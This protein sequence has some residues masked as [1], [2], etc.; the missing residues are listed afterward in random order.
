MS[1]SSAPRPSIKAV[2][3]DLD[4]TLLDTEQ[5]SDKA[6]LM[7]F[8]RDVLPTNV[9][10]ECEANNFLLPWELKKQL[11][12]LRGSE[13]APK[14]IA[15]AHQHWGVP[16]DGSLE[17]MTV[18]GIW[19]KWE[20]ALNSLCEEVESCDGALKL[21]RL[22]AKKGFPMAIATSSR[23]AAVDKK[24]K[25]HENMFQHISKIVAGDNSAVKSGKPAPDIYLEAAR[26]LG[27]D[28]RE[29]VVFE[30]ALSGVEAGKAAGCQVV[31]V[32]DSRFNTDEKQVFHDKADVV[33]DS[34]WNFS[35][36]LW[37]IDVDMA[38]EKGSLN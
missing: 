30:D 23:Q 36:D 26:Q 11:L 31:A 38:K 24:R 5:L 35:G 18:E 25:R 10:E 22:F 7:A 34:L 21:V 17:V 29:C 4:G 15:Y 32:P 19:N 27:V 13:W 12:G 2:L 9:W 16:D 33:L 3:F 28:P 1:G 6:M 37:G 8:G 14:A 20:I